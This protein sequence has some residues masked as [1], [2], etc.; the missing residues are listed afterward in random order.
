MLNEES[1][2]TVRTTVTLPKPNYE[3]IERIAREKRVSVA[4]VVREAVIEYLASD[5]AEAATPLKVRK[6]ARP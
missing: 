1:E 5:S 6:D 3:E 2:G 4:W